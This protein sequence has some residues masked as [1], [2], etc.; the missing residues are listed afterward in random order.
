MIDRFIGAIQ[1]F[2]LQITKRTTTGTSGAATC[3]GFAG[4]VTTESLTTAAG[5]ELSYTITNN[6][7]KSS[8][9]VLPSVSNGTNTTVAASVCTVTPANG[10]FVVVV[11]NTH[12]SAA[13]DGTLKINFV[14]V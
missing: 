1:Q 7:V 11:S 14:I 13:F 4:V 3:H 9:I 8:S 12:E 10:S 5:A 6:K 2:G